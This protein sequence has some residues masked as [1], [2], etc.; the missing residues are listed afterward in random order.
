MAIQWQKKKQE[1]RLAVS[2][3][4]RLREILHHEAMIVKRTAPSTLRTHCRGHQAL[5]LFLPLPFAP[6]FLERS[7]SRVMIPSWRPQK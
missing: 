4:L 2:L 7:T 6:F 5:L 3:F 1:E